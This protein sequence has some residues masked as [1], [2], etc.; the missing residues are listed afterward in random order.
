M[1]GDDLDCV[2][3]TVAEAL[4]RPVVIA[5]PAL[6]EPVVA[7][8]GAL[9]PEQLAELS[10]FAARLARDEPVELPGALTDG[11][12][13]RIGDRVVGVAATGAGQRSAPATGE[14]RAWLEAAAA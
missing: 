7:P 12:P 6:G 11:V 13:V 2:T 3:A 1:A 8:P 14:P 10:G 4:G 9:L 5:I